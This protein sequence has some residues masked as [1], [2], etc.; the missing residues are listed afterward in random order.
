MHITHF[1]FHYEELLHHRFSRFYLGGPYVTRHILRLTGPHS[2]M[3]HA[4]KMRVM[5]PD[6]R[7]Y[8]TSAFSPDRASYM[9]EYQFGDSDRTVGQLL[10]RA[11]L[12]RV[13]PVSHNAPPKCL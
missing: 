8:R 6:K 10:S 9:L 4:S 1:G 13:G 7:G 11:N 5:T 3:P 12:D 2:E